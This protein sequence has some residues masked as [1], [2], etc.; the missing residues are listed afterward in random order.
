MQKL[1]VVDD[2]EPMVHVIEQILSRVGYDVVTETEPEAAVARAEAGEHFDLALLDVVMPRLSGETLAA[3]LRRRD[4]DLK[5]LYVTGYDD[6]LFRA[7]PVLWEGESFL[8]KPFTP[9]GLREAV[10][11]ALFGMTSPPDGT[12]A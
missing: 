10:S 8:E 7:R 1:L 5:V 9:E 6:A 4:P 12:A 11:V 3:H 2:D